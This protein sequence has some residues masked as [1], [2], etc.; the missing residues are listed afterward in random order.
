MHRGGGH[1]GVE[2]KAAVSDLRPVISFSSSLL[3]IPYFYYF[4]DI[5][6]AFSDENTPGQHQVYR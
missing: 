1:D 5:G 3:F 4:V 6:Y 2:C